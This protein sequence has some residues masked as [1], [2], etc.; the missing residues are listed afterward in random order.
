[1]KRDDSL[2]GVSV[3]IAGAGLAGLVAARELQRCG[4][5]LQI[6]EARERLG[7]RV[8]TWRDGFA[9]GQHVEGGG[10][11]IEES[12]TEILR[13]AAELGLR[14][15]RILRRGFSGVYS[16][17]TRESKYRARLGGRQES[18]EGTDS[19]LSRGSSGAGTV[20]SR[21]P[22]RH[23]G[24]KLARSHRASAEMRSTALAMRGFFL[25][26]PDDS[27][28]AALV[29]QFATRKRRARVG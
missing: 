10:D 14:P 6:V 18:L 19:R 15:V 24:H 17:V 1:M 21:S 8:W 22:R 27:L 26:D 4:A 11:L 23:F 7:G 29:D 25:A 12:Q 9:E 13:L 2:R 28:A 16:S 3:L 5:E 20:Q